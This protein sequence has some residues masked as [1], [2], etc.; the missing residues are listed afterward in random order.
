MPIALPA[1]Q[2]ARAPAG[3]RVPLFLYGTLLDPACFAAV[4]GSS[5]PLRAGRAALLRGARRVTLRGTPW[6]TLVADARGAVPGRVVRVG[7]AMLRR[8]CR[9]EGPPYRL[10]PVAPRAR[11]R[12]LPAFAWIAPR[13]RAD[14][15][16]PWRPG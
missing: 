1:R 14:A 6:P 16:R 11:F 15:A 3:G 9:Y 7:P 10:C 12:V 5:A 4:A 8:L 13:G 2:A